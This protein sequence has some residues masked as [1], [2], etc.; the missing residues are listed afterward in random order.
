MIARCQP[1]FPNDA[2]ELKGAVPFSAP[3]G[4]AIFLGDELHHDEAPSD[5]PS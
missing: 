5:T 2:K 1:A 3:C 4:G